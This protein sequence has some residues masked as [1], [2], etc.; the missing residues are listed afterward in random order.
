[1]FASMKRSAHSNFSSSCPPK[2]ALT[3]T[4]ASLPSNVCCAYSQHERRCGQYPPTRQIRVNYTTSEITQDLERKLLKTIIY[5]R[6]I[7]WIWMDTSSPGQE[8]KCKL[9]RWWK[10]KRLMPHLIWTEHGLWQIIYNCF[11]TCQNLYLIPLHSKY[12]QISDF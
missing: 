10:N 1:M 8:N 5:H 12:S 2:P 11:S 9:A 3:A 4:L 6:P 7:G